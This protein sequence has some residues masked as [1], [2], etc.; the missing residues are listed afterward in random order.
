MPLAARLGRYKDLARFVAK[1]GRA[2]FLK[3]AE[4]EPLDASQRPSVPDA[5]SFARDLEA[6]G[7]TFIKLGQLLST[8]ADLL[9]QSYL[10]ALARLQDDV[11]PFPCDEAQRIVEEELGV[12]LSKAFL[13]FDPQ[14]IAAASLGQVHHAVLREGRE[15]AVKVQRPGIRERVVQDLDAL[16][17]VAALIDRFSGAAR[18]VDAPRLLQEFRRT[19]MAELDYREEARNL[20][21]LAT[22]LADFERIVVPLPVDDYTTARVLTMDYVPGTKITAVSP[23]E[24]TEVDGA[25]LA[26]ELFRAYLQQILIDGVFHAD[27]HPGNVLLTPGP[28]TPRSGEGG[29]GGEHR[30]ALVDLGMVGRLSAAMQEQLFKLLLAISEGRGDEAAIV[31]ISLGEKRDDFDEAGVRRGVVEMVGRYHHSALKD[32]N[33]GRVMLEIARSSSQHGLK[34]APELALLGKTLLNLDEIARV[35]DPTFDVNA[36]MRQN[37][38]ALMRRRMLKSATPSNLFAAALEVR[39]FAERLPGRVNRILD[40]LASNDLRLKIEVID[41]GSIL[42]GFQ[43]VA[44]RIAL[45]LVLAAL[46]VGAAMLM[47]V[48]TPFTI[49]GYPGLAI[50][51]FLAAAAGGFWMAWTI[52]FSDVH[53][54]RVR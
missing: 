22:Q 18:H 26:D 51:L 6:L 32:L 38:N 9:P 21:A 31:A 13:T 33:V 40:A 7:P 28:P 5:E 43:K 54:R 1:Y 39:D 4:I 12:R 3:H 52:L 47:R 42:E 2:D 45:G 41:Q 14:P 35:L 24:R 15:V 29:E 16:D 44:N 11:D 50:L 25:A 30:L 17:E 48:P 19:L 46:I 36:S 23:L 37:A 34:L 27:P 49:L 53:Q 8:R 10:D 20:T